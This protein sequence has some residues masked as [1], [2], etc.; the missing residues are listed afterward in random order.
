[1]IWLERQITG[2][3]HTVCM[4]RG[5]RVPTIVNELEHEPELLGGQIHSKQYASLK[6][7]PQVTGFVMES[8][9]LQV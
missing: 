8:K 1:M 5:S 6:F 7:W 2:L 9:F 3:S 4:Y